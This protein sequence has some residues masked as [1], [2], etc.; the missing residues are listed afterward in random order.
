MNTATLPPQLSDET[1]KRFR[2]VVVARTGLLFGPRQRNSLVSRVLAAAERAGCKS[3]TLELRKFPPP[4]SLIPT[5]RL[6][7]C[8]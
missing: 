3:L 4:L 1:Y 2:E 7:R 6:K 5:E 8:E